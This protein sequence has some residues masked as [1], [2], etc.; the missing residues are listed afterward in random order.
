[1]TCEQDEVELFPIERQDNPECQSMFRDRKFGRDSR[2][3]ERG[4]SFA[5]IHSLFG[6][7]GLYG[8]RRCQRCGLDMSLATVSCTHVIDTKSATETSFRGK[9]HDERHLVV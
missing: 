3:R 9:A 4:R 5:F 8:T 1:M 7:I 2:E 6:R